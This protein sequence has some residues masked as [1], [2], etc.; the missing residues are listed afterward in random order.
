M[1]MC[2][3]PVDVAHDSADVTDNAAKPTMLK[4][5]RKP[6]RPACDVTVSVAAV[7]DAAR[8]ALAALR[9]H[10][11]VAVSSSVTDLCSR[12]WLCVYLSVTDIDI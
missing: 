3:T 9:R 4:K 7:S 1:D 6:E 2:F 5:P 8:C 11:A 12:V 10:R